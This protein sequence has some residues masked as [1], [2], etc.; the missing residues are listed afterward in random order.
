MRNGFAAVFT[1]LLIAG[2]NKDSGGPSTPT[3]PT[4][5]INSIAIAIA[6]EILVAGNTEQATATASFS[7]GTTQQVTG[8]WST[9]NSA[10][11]TV[12]QTGRVTGQG[13]GR[14]ALLFSSGGVSASRQFRVVPNYQGQWSGSYFITGCS[15]SGTIA[16]VNFCRDFPNNRV[17]PMSMTLTQG[18]RD[19]VEGRT[20]LGTLQ[21]DLLNGPV[22]TDGAVQ[23][24]GIIRSGDT[25]IDIF[26][27]FNALQS[28]RLVGGL[29]QTWRVA[30]VNGQALVT[31]E[32]RD[33]N[34]TSG[35]ATHAPARTPATPRSLE[36]VVRALAQP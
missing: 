13:S 29:R 12:D 20:F 1:V 14:A 25:A 21:S 22:E 23:F 31:G 33:M 24:S 19:V 32:F 6:N 10:V 8:T 36:D 3:T 35:S 2:C 18:T 17:L 26:W 15:Q 11:A 30:G 4:P 28:G 5:T 34:R 27:R 7:N 9:D 16:I